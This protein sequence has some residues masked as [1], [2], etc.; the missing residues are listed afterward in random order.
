[1]QEHRIRARN[2]HFLRRINMKNLVKIPA[3]AAVILTLATAGVSSAR[4]GGWPIAAGVVG[5]FAAG[6]IVARAVAPPY[7]VCPPRVYVAPYCA[8]VRVL[9]APVPACYV[10]APLVYPAYYPPVRV[11]VVAGRPHY[12]RR[13]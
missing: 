11:V 7:Y 4:A 9:A 5:G 13:W 3:V 12:F 8:P 1:M 6:T 2:R 10:P